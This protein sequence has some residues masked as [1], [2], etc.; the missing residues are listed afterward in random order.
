M[1]HTTE[2]AHSVEA[3]SV[4]VRRLVVGWVANAMTQSADG[5]RPETVVA[6]DAVAQALDL[7][8]G[9]VDPR[10]I[11]AKGT[12]DLVTATDLAI[13]DAI[14]A[15]VGAALGFT[16]IGEERGG[17]APADG[18]PYWLVDPIC[19]TRNL[20]SGIPLYCVNLA[21]VED[22]QVTAAVVGDPSTGEICVAEL[23]QGAWAM[24]MK[25]GARR[26]LATSE[27][28]RTVVIEDSHAT[29]ARHELAAGF[30]AGAIRADRWDLRALSTTLSLA[31]VAAG[32]IAAY[33]LFWTSAVHVGAGSLLAAEAGAIVSEIGG[34]PWTIHSDSI[35]ASAT[36]DLHAALLELAGSRAGPHTPMARRSSLGRS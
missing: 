10:S 16:A 30:T 23:G 2:P 18:L 28:S 19:G 6:I 33:V 4:Q 20:A 29:G 3:G 13:E 5:F 9:G 31:Y 35:L 32:R 7:A 24:A 34:Q 14:R 22:G 1:R 15:M 12:R 21:L 11:T 27:Q 17:Q 8:R 36:P 26:R 25:D